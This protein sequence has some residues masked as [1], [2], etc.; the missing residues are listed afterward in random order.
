LKPL[1]IFLH[2]YAGHPF[3]A[4]LSRALAARGHKVIHA[5][6]AGDP[7]PKGDLKVKPGDAVGLSFLPI[8]IDEPYTK[9]N[10]FKRRQLDHKYGRAAAAAI[11][12][13]GADIV[14]SGNTPTEAQEFIVRACKKS[15]ARFV[16]WCQDFYSVAVSKLAAKLLPGIG[17]L[18]GHYYTALERGQ[19]RAADGVLMITDDFTPIAL[20][21]GVEAS[22]IHVPP[23]WG[24][25]DDIPVLPK[26]NAWARE[27]GL[28]DRKVFLYS[29]TIGL[30]HNPEL[31]VALAQAHRNDPAV[32]VVVNAAGLGVP[33][34]EA[35]KAELGLDNL[36]LLGLQPFERFAE[37]LATAD[38]LTAVIERDAGTFS[39]PSKVLSYLCAKRAILL[40]APEEN[41]AARNVAGVKAGLVVDP[42]D[43]AAFLAAAREMLNPAK[44]DA[45]AAAGRAYAQANF[46]IDR[47]T[48]RAE[49]ILSAVEL[50]A[51]TNPAAERENAPVRT[52]RVHGD[53]TVR[54]A[55]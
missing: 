52:N 35:R 33:H 32:R 15:G 23:N 29:G 44:A 24:A 54:Q 16:F 43:Q 42:D 45:M 7:G 36:L 50:A 31:L 27:H 39:V 8:A 37:V 41:L 4:Q 3:Q 6:F 21:W 49:A 51:G 25:I 46:D 38:V 19:M 11:A 14:L 13:S 48:D 20:K 30:K 1:T 34:L 28:V 18:I 10:F 26:D 47:V 22:R 9:G 40:A 53:A 5:F 55:T 17:L 2:D 12:A